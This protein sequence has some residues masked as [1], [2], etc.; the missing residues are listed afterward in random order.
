MT[1][2]ALEAHFALERLAALLADSCDYRPD[3]HD[4]LQRAMGHLDA[5]LG[6]R[7]ELAE[8]FAVP[9]GPADREGT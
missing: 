7:T 6:R 3:P 1:L 2:H 8:R 5:I 9:G 4:P